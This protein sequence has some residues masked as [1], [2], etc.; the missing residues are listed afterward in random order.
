MELRIKPG[1]PARSPGAPK[2]HRD[3]MQ[4]LSIG[5]DKSIHEAMVIEAARLGRSQSNMIQYVLGEFLK[6]PDRPSEY[7][8]EVESLAAC[9]SAVFRASMISQLRR[10]PIIR[11]NGIDTALVR[12]AMMQAVKSVWKTVGENPEDFS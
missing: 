1:L 12:R 5:I 6:A 11:E 10:K 7:D 3:G 2:K 4:N 8:L 9:L